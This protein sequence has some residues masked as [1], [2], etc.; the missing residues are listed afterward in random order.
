MAPTPIQSRHFWGVR[1]ILAELGYKN[2]WSTWKLLQKQG[3]P[4]YTRRGVGRQR[5][6]SYWYTNSDMI[7]VWN[8]RKAR[9]EQIER[10]TPQATEARRRKHSSYAYR[11]HKL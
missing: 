11:R 9:A 7:R 4:A 8:L 6:K 3:F 5:G 2:R 1:S 10:A